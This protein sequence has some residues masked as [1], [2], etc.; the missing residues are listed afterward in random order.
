MLA[1]L[2][3][4]VQEG[5]AAGVSQ[6]GQAELLESGYQEEP[7]RQAPVLPEVQQ[8]NEDLLRQKGRGLHMCFKE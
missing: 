1:H 2:G 8:G 3:E 6:G 5:A 4:A 7:L